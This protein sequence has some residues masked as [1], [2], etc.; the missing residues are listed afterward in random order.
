LMDDLRG[1]GIAAVISGAGPSVLAL[2][3]SDMDL[4]RWQRRGFAGR[5]VPI[6]DTGATITES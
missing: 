4:Q 5:Q 2:V 1:A 6:C 3:T